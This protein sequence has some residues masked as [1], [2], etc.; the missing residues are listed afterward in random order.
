M[1][2]IW[3]SLDSETLNDSKYA[4]PFFVSVFLNMGHIIHLKHVHTPIHTLYSIETNA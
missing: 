1:I 4:L 2:S 3:I